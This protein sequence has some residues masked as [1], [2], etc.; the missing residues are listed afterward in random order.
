MLTRPAEPH[1]RPR[2]VSGWLAFVAVL[3]F[4]MVVVGGVTRLT[5]SGLSMVRWE[6]ISGAIPPLDEADWQAEFDHYK[7]SPQYSQV[8]SGIT[9]A[10]FKAIF[11]WEYVHRLLGRLI[12]LAFALPLLFFWWRRSIP[13]GYGWKLGTLFGLGALQ[14]VVGWWMVASG[15]VDVPEVSHIRLA[16][17]LLLALAIFAALIWVSRD[18]KLAAR[19][20]PAPPSRAPL[21]GLWTLSLLFL[22]FLF[23]AYVAGLDAG[24]AFNSWPLMGG[25]LYPAGAEW[26]QPALRNFVDNPITVQFVHRWLAFVVAAVAL[27]LAAQ[28]WARGFRQEAVLLAGALIAQIQLGILT[29]LSGVQI[30]LAV[31][32]QGMA[33]LLLGATVSAAHRLGEKGHG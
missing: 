10:D 23:G 9:L 12:G 21:L 19:T 17:H 1:P 33:A 24:Y 18:L 6:P 32:H 11:F 2:A 22:Q 29:L 25:E 5:E 8:N 15:L 7:T 28:A 3:V 16:V 26:M 13:P 4:L 14:G 27:W 20:P 31:A 30:D